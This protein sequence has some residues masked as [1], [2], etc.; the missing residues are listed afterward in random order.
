MEK[1]EWDNKAL[2]YII[3]VIEAGGDVNTLDCEE[4]LEARVKVRSPFIFDGKTKVSTHPDYVK[5]CALWWVC[6]G[7]YFWKADCDKRGL[8]SSDV[9]WIAPQ[10]RQTVSMSF[11][12]SKAQHTSV[13]Y[14][15]RLIVLYI[16]AD[17]VAGLPLVRGA[18]GSVNYGRICESSDVVDPNKVMDDS[19]Y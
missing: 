10:I 9:Y 12:K 18:D 3:R 4:E 11:R 16:N 8:S 7:V 19:G 15:G 17:G 13:N 14:Q 6:E 1:A 2:D 5:T